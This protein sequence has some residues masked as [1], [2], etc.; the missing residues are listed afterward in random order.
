MFIDIQGGSRSEMG[1]ASRLWPSRFIVWFCA[2]SYPERI[3]F[4]L[5]TAEIIRKFIFELLLGQNWYT[6]PTVALM[7][8]LVQLSL[9]HAVWLA[10]GKFR[11]VPVDTPIL[12]LS[13]VWLLMSAH[14]VVIGKLQGNS[15]FAIINDTVPTILC[16]VTLVRFGLMSRV[17]Y[18][19]AFERIR[20]LIYCT[21][22]ICTVIGMIAVNLGLPSRASPSAVLFAIFG[23]MQMVLIANKQRGPRFWAE[24]LIFNFVFFAA[25]NRCEP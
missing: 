12:V 6:L 24:F 8:F 9:D 17:N 20:C 1:S 7:A 5:C 21:A 2:L 23:A 16:L 19:L 18:T 4:Y 10:R 15:I 14:G 13:V 22:L 11:G 25:A 3:L